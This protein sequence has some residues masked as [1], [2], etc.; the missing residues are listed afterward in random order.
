MPGPS[1]SAAEIAQLT[2]EKAKAESAA[3]TFAASV[4]AMQA[5]AVELSVADGAFKKFFDYYNTDIIGKYDTEQRWINGRILTSPVVEADITSCANLEGGRLQPSLPTTDIIRIVQFD[6]TPTTTDTDNELQ[7]LTDQATWETR[8]TSGYGGTAPAN[9]V[10]TNSSITAASTTLQLK[11]LTTTFALTVGSVF[12]VTVGGD[13]AVFKVN[14]FT[15]QSSP[16]PPPYVADLTIE[17]I[18][19]PSGTIAS[20]QQLVAFTGFTNTERTN[21]VPSDVAY[22]PLMNYLIAQLQAQINSRITTLNNQLTAIAANLDPEPGSE[23]TTATT[24]VNTSKTFLTNYLVT[25]I[26]S[27]TGL[28]SLSTERSTRTTQANARV[29]QITNAYTGR[30]KNYYNE[31]YNAANNRANTSRG[32]L[33]IQKAS[34]QAATTSQ[35]FSDSLTAQASAISAILP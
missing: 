2:K 8:L 13:L 27:N 11:D 15:M 14:S 34:E 20:G 16:V 17:L 29:T 26:I 3:A 10:L 31:R 32:S 12:V 9:T 5:R 35:G 25:T 33:R 24:N 18:V 22:Q 28:T 30:T 4:A 6:G 23:L 21:K 7:H 19:A 1:L